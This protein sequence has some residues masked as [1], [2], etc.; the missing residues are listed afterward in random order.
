ME[1]DFRE[2]SYKLE[3]LDDD[4]KPRW[5]KMT[6]QHML[7]HLIQVLR[8]S[9]GKLVLKCINPVE[10]LP[11]L[12]RFL[13]SSRELPKNF[14]NP[15]IGEGLIPLEYANFGDALAVLREEIVE[16]DKFYDEKPDVKT[17]NPTFGELNYDEWE[18]FHFKHFTHHLKQFGVIK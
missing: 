2:L 4:S 10:K 11:V 1:I 14:V 8:C 15:I 12:K 16:H 6:S 9:N 18:V 17:I 3:K 7:E 13:L 5:G